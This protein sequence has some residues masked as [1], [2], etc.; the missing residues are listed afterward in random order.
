METLLLILNIIM[1]EVLQEE[2]LVVV[3][4]VQLQIRVI[5]EKVVVDPLAE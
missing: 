4:V 3:V 2:P 1:T 5:G